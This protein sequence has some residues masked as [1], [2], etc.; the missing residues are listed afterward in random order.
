MGGVQVLP[1]TAVAPLVGTKGGGGG[2]V[3]AHSPP[4]SEVGPSSSSTVSSDLAT[5]RHTSH[6]SF[7]SGPA[8]E[9]QYAHLTSTSECGRGQGARARGLVFGGAWAGVL[10][11][12]LVFGSAYW[13]LEARTGVWP[14]VLMFGGV[15][16]CLA[17]CAGVWRRVQVF[18]GVCR[19][20][21][22]C[23]GVW[24]RV[25]VFGGVR[26]CLCRIT[27]AGQHE[28]HINRPVNN[29]LDEETITRTNNK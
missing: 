16:R 12:C 17:A 29:T 20:L 22:A 19:C 25:Q 26:R 4:P 27:V 21:A 23:A 28:S 11:R 6:S 10:E 18:G 3:T 1:S 5:T 14:R 24:R 7:A 15:R 9:H 13:C 2:R 8:K